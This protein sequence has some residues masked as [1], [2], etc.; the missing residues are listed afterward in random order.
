MTQNTDIFAE[1]MQIA[2]EWVADQDSRLSFTAYEGQFTHLNYNWRDDS[3][4][5]SI[6]EP[7]IMDEKLQELPWEER[8]EYLKEMIRAILRGQSIEFLDALFG[9]QDIKKAA[10]NGEAAI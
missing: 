5:G 4:N 9:S 6:I 10:P 1:L 3:T 7:E 2:E 8:R